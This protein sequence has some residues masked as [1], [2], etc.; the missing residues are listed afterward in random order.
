MDFLRR[1][2]PLRDTD[3]TRAV[4]VLPSRFASESP[5]RTGIESPDSPRTVLDAGDPLPTRGAEGLPP[6]VPASGVSRREA[7]AGEPSRSVPPPTRG[8]PLRPE[9]A[10]PSSLQRTRPADTPVGAV[11]AAHASRHHRPAAV[12]HVPPAD[13]QR[14]GAAPTATAE[15]RAAPTPPTQALMNLPLSQ[16]AVA[17][18]VLASRD[19]SPVVHVT[20]GR[21]DVVAGTPLPATAARRGPKAPRPATVTL[22]DYLRAANGGRR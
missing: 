22:A 15:L 5:L 11:A 12:E 10:P 16:V 14:P 18:R 9:G 13:P 19:D 1:L 7:V 8:E 17:Q 6:S 4:A 21:I 3:T 2:A 20:I